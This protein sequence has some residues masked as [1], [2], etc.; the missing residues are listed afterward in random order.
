MINNFSKSMTNTND[1]HTIVFE[2]L[3]I[4]KTIT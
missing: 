1:K 4:K 3:T 2:D